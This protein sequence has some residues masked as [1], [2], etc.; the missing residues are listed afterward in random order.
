MTGAPRG[1]CLFSGLLILA[2]LL[3]AA[4]ARATYIG[5][6]HF[7]FFLDTA[8]FRGRDGKV[9]AEVGIRIPNRAL[10]YKQEGAEWQSRV[11]L[12]VLIVDD[13]GKEV[14]KHA[15][16]MT[17]S[18]AD[19]QSPESPL[20]FQTVIKQ[21]LLPPGGYWLSYAVEDLNA[22]VLSVVGLVRDENRNAAVRRARLHLPEIP[23]DE[24]SFSDALFVWDIDP[25]E[26][27]IRKYRPNPSRMYGLYRDTLTVYVELYLPDDVARAPTFDFRTEIVTP[28]G[29]PVRETKRTLP[30]PGE[31]GRPL[32]TYPVVLR[33]DLTRMPA[34]SYTL[35]LTFALEGKTIARV[36]SGDFSVAW[37]MRTWETPRREFLAEAR[38]LLGD[39]EFKAFQGRTP[40]EQEQ[41]LDAAWKKYDPDP[42]TGNNEAYD[43]FLER[44]AYVK[45]H[46]GEGRP[47]I[48][49]ARGDIYLRYGPP[50]DV[51]QDVVPLNYDTLAEA[52]QVVENPY[53]PLN[54]TSTNQK[55]YGITKSRNSLT[56]EGSSAR[57]RQED[58]TAVPF[59]LW[60]YQAGGNPIL[61]RDEVHELDMGMRFLFVDKD[62]HGQYVLEKSSSISNK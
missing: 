35:Y 11:N 22:P 33:E 21:Y 51:V 58:N 61:K 1:A 47:A 6:G 24:A 20:T 37:D 54:M 43:T 29:D 42:E 26:Q 10:K 34:G 16:Q 59:E 57:Y 13:Q 30:N 28:G 9:L 39:D 56:G 52:E 38:F 46:Y 44:L 12:S 55:L 7:D 27:G 23:D 8:A 5:T 31:A 4:P 32:T 15:E 48:F 62:G 36:K 14:I 18:E 3:A 60:V 45:A 17:F 19:E 40:G 49:S 41:I 2:T 50:D 25:A 53:H